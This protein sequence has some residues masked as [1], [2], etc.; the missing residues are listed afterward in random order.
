MYHHFL[1]NESILTV[2]GTYHLIVC[3]KIKKSFTVSKKFRI[4]NFLR[5]KNIENMTLTIV[6]NVSL[7]FLFKK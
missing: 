5:P 1:I 7:I 4:F 2:L 6:D 3:S